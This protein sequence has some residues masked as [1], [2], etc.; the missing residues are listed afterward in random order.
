[1]RSRVDLGA[2]ARSCAL[3]VAIAG[4]GA[5]A[6]RIE[7]V[8]V[9]AVPGGTCGRP[10]DAKT[11]FV[12]ALGDFPA[13][14]RSLGASAP[15]SFGDFPVDTRQFTV[16]IL[17]ANGAIRAI[18]KTRPLVLG[19]LPD[20]TRVPVMMAPPDGFCPVGAMSAARDRPLVVR[21]GAG[22]LVL[23]GSDDG[24][25]LHTAEYYDPAT[26][27]FSPVAV[28][29][30]YATALAFTG[31]AATAMPDG[32]AVVTGG[33]SAAYVVF[34]PE[35]RAYTPPGALGQVRAYHAAVALPDDKIALFGGCT[36]LN[37]T[38]GECEPGGADPT[39]AVVVALTNGELAVGPRAAV[40]R[41]GGSARLEAGGSDLAGPPQLL[42][43]GGVNALGQPVT[44][45]E[46]A[47][48]TGTATAATAPGAPGIA[49]PLASGA[50][51][52]G[53]APPGAAAAGA[54]AVIPPAGDAVPVGATIAR[55]DAA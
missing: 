8:P 24:A 50:I 19:E 29:S 49:A 47:D 4:C 28:P 34:D 55:A 10:A 41:L 37:Q 33:A 2:L 30:V 21:L 6:I 32:R 44:V 38:T 31:A 7:L 42:V 14:G 51:L 15:A 11:L 12:T 36:L 20:G 43:V 22:A 35:T 48:P 25:P 13:E 54:A 16:E 3:G 17:G 27:R 52:V 5:D 45:S 53:F 39:A 9:D 46:R 18:G 26:G 1:M 23:G 40:A